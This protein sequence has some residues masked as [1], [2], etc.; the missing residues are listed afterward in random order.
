MNNTKKPLVG[1]RLAPPPCSAPP[2]LNIRCEYN[3][4]IVS[5][6]TYLNV[7]RVEAEDDGSFTAVTDHWPNAG[8]SDW[9]W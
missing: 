4:G 9:K 1:S 7:I 2:R 8:L 6:S 3:D 5:G